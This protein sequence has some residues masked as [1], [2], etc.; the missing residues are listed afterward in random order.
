MANEKKIKIVVDKGGAQRA[1]DQVTTKLDNAGI[2]AVNLN[3]NIGKLAGAGRVL[4]GVAGGIGLAAAA[5]TKYTTQVTQAVTETDNL[6][7]QAGVTINTFQAWERA[8]K[9]LG[10]SGDELSQTLA[11]VSDRVGEFTRTGGGEFKDVYE[12]YIKPMGVAVDDLRTMRPDEILNLIKKGM[13]EAGASANEMKSALEQVASNADRLNP[14]LDGTGAK[15]ERITKAMDERGQLFTPEEVERSKVLNEKMAVLNDEVSTLGTSIGLALVEPVTAAV[16]KV[17]QIIGYMREAYQ[18]AKDIENMLGTDAQRANIK[19]MNA[20]QGE[21]FASNESINR[22]NIL[23]SFGYDVGTAKGSTPYKPTGDDKADSLAK[24]KERELAVQKEF[25]ARFLEE[26]L[27]LNDSEAMQIENWRSDQFERL[28]EYHEKNLIA[29]KDYR[30]ALAAIN[31]N[32]DAKQTELKEKERQKELASKKKEQQETI[33]LAG[34]TQTMLDNF[35]NMAKG[36]SDSLNAL[37][38]GAAT[39]QAT[40]NM[41]LAAS[42]AMANWDDFSP[43]QKAA[44]VSMILGMGAGLISGITGASRQG[45][46]AMS[47]TY[48]VGGGAH[49]SA[50]E[51]FTDSRTGKSYMTGDGFM[52]PAHQL[53]SGQQNADV[54]GVVVNLTNNGEPM[55]AVAR[56]GG[57]DEN[58]VRQIFMDMFPDQLAREAGDP[59]SRFNETRST[60]ERIQP[61]FN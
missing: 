24:Q 14:I 11:D 49:T 17:N 40:I 47:G 8:T 22:T 18:I 16:E 45:G 39:F 50:P 56:D 46:G 33:N 4:G 7:R 43:I 54:G 27:R 52:T 29:T 1:I 38:Q 9:S 53:K 57:V 61:E 28:A 34:Q 37:A 42:Q 13:L 36:R 44:N 58:G 23:G 20:F 5:I 3:S 15:I 21:E 48:Q 26:T 30:E 2:S 51:L 10:V 55:Q 31:A 35:A 6:A 19:R 12:Q 60:I 59:S 25:A 32:A 41:Y